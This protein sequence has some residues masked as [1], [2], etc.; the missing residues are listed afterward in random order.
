MAPADDTWRRKAQVALSA[1]ATLEEVEA[2]RLQ[3]KELQD[4]QAFLAWLVPT[5]RTCRR[6]RDALRYAKR[7]LELWRQSEDLSQV[8]NSL[9][10]IAELC[11]NLD[12]AFGR[13]R[14]CG[15]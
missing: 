1:G 10:E 11:I 15:G 3:L 7:Q 4:E 5:L 8:A 14:C 2:A 12:E 13:A 9:C 6:H